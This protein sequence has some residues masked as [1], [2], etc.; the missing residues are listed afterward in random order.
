MAK[1]DEMEEITAPR[2]VENEEKRVLFQQFL[3]EHFTGV[4]PNEVAE[5][6]LSV[7]ADDEVFGTEVVVR[8]ACDMFDLEGT[9]VD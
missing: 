1:P 3:E 7:L 8:E 9:P 4:E 2:L 5:F 6:V